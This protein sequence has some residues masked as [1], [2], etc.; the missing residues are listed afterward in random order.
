MFG[1]IKNM[2]KINHKNHGFLLGNSMKMVTL[3]QLLDLL[4]IHDNEN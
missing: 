4:I 2:A 1:M 3:T